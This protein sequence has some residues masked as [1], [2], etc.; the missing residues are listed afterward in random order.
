MVPKGPDWHPRLSTL[1]RLSQRNEIQILRPEIIG[2]GKL[3][4]RNIFSAGGMFW[5]KIFLVF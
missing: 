4:A 3:P 2:G 1:G 5:L